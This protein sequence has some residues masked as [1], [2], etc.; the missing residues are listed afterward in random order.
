MG[1][2]EKIKIYGLGFVLIIVG[3]IVA[4]Q[5]VEPAPPRKFSIATGSKSG[6]YFHFAQ[7]YHAILAREGLELEI[8]NTKGSVDNIERLE[9]GEADVAFVQSGTAQDKAAKPENTFTSLGSLYYEPLWVFVRQELPAD[10]L[11][12]L[13]GKRIAA[14]VEGSGTWVVA[15][16][17][18]E[19]N[20]LLSGKAEILHLS[21]D[22]AAKGLLAGTV[23]AAF[24][25][26][27]LESTVIKELIEAPTLKLMSFER[28]R[29][30]TQKHRFLSSVEL[31]QGVVSLRKNLPP[32]DITM[33]APAATLV[34]SDSL[35]PALVSL[36]VQAMTE[37]HGGGSILDEPGE[38]PSTRYVDFPMNEQAVRY[39][40]NGQ[41]F[42]QRYLPF[43]L[44]VL[45][46]QLKVFLVP[47]IALMLPLGKI[48][49]P[50]YRWR[51]RSKIYRYYRDL[52]DIEKAGVDETDVAKLDDLIVQLDAMQQELLRL[53]VP[54]SY[55]EELYQLRLHTNMVHDTMLNMRNSRT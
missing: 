36:L 3:F 37:V 51:I 4:Y 11:G 5:F 53:T 28:A 10:N 9:K 27:S 25:V 8:I 14:G 32:H 21:S 12:A 34:T 23:D 43:W 1:I 42:L 46:D 7:R 31:P 29:A 22:E 26:A 2:G 35:H 48:L 15:K 52:K 33:L 40:K 30:Y 6:A 54:L 44:A 13:A 45:I 18:L 19:L 47:L 49:P 39:I 55:S 20:D 38:F 17:A 24:F 50:T 16:Q 41:P